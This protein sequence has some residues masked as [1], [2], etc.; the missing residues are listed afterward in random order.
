[1]L[2]GLD[3]RAQEASMSRLERFRERKDALFAEGDQSPL[4]PEQQE[5]FE[6]LDYFPENPALDLT[7]TIDRANAGS[8]PVVDTIDG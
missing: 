2:A 4:D 7:L 5:R 3:E 1:M 8:D 6:K